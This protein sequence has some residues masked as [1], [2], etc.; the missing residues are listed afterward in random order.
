MADLEGWLSVH[1]SV[2]SCLDSTRTGEAFYRHLGYRNSTLPTL[3]N[4]LHAL[5]MHKGLSL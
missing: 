3:R 4:G 2:R 5:P 1:G